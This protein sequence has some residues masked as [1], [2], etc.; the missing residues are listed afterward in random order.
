[1]QVS[2]YRKE[3]AMELKYIDM[4]T[5]Y[6]NSKLYQD[7]PWLVNHPHGKNGW[8]YVVIDTDKSPIEEVGYIDI[9]NYKTSLS[10]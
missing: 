10:I 7:C 2:S 6:V 4:H 3:K 8:G 5:F 9:T 1:M